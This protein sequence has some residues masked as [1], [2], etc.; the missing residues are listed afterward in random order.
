MLHVQKYLKSGKT[1]EDLKNEHGVKSNVA[2]GKICLN[3]DQIEASNSD[4]LACQCRGL[5]LRE[6]NYEIVACPMFRFFN[7]EQKEVAADIDWNSA[8][9]EEK[10]D[11]CLEYNT[12]IK[13]NFGSRKIGELV[14]GNFK[15]KVLSYDPITNTVEYDDVIAVSEKDNIDN[16]YELELENGNIIQVTSNHKVYVPKINAYKSVED[17]DGTEELLIFE[18][19][20]KIKSLKKIKLSSKRYDLQTKKN[21][22]FFAN[23]ILVHN[24]CIIVYFDDI[25]DKWCCG[26]RNRSEADANINDINFTFANL[27]DQTIQVMWNSKNPNC[28]RN[29]S[30]QDLMQEMDR[31]QTV[32]AKK[33]TFVFELTSPVNR[34]VCKYDESKLTLLAV[35]NNLT[36]EEEFPQV[37]TPI[38][39]FGIECTKTYSFSNVNH[40]IQV[41]REWNPEDHEGVVVKDKYWNRIKVKNPAY[42]SFNHMRDSLA[43]SFRG[44]VEIILLG[45]EDD[46]I[47]MMSEL[48]AKRIMRLKSAID[49]VILQTQRDYDELRHI[50]DIKEFAL[51]AQNKLWKGALFALKRGK[52][53]DLKTFALGNKP[54]VVKIPTSAVDTMLKLIKQVDPDVA[55]LEL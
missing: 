7:L 14:K 51:A 20:V 49:K 48:I 46:V 54:G 5:V 25:K 50:E 23:G 37:W 17:L 26:T 11:G 8:I 38:E 1:L 10:M 52:T 9:Y 44:C 27:V 53:P 41:I 16:W 18:E 36:L 13:T 22:N 34:I 3:Y 29:V 21:N 12:V 39:K 35:R 19:V 45:K 43:T 15:G 32:D 55:R 30:L 2:H 28:N 47:G 31:F 6:G 33:R 42:I 24:S 4:E 40:M